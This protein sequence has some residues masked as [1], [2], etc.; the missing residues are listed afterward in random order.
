MALRKLIGQQLPE[1]PTGAGGSI[2]E[3]ILAVPQLGAARL[4]WD[5]FRDLQ[6]W[7]P[8]LVPLLVWVG[9]STYRKERAAIAGETS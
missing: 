7:W 6:P 1:P 9:V 8:V 2:V 5:S 3:Q 4:F